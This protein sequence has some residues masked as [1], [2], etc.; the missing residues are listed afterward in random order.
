M[1]PRTAGRET[2]WVSWEVASEAYRWW[3]NSWTEIRRPTITTKTIT[4]TSRMA[5]ER[6]LNR[7]EGLTA[8]PGLPDA[9]VPAPDRTVAGDAAAVCGTGRGTSSGTWGR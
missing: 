2:V 1:P 7:T 5:R 3:E 6:L 9:A 8:R 4:R